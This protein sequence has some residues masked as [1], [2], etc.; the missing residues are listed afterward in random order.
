MT[1]KLLAPHLHETAIAAKKYFAA[2]HGATHFQ[3]EAE[4]DAELSL[5]PTFFAQLRNGYLLC[6]EVSEKAFSN[7]L[8][9]FVVE[10]SSRGFPVKLVVALP[11][12]KGDPEF[13][14]ILHRLLASTAAAGAPALRW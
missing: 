2:E 4:V 10:C 5:K 1:F 13:A 8:D 9:T 14:A 6:V 12:A 11:S 3:I 7:S